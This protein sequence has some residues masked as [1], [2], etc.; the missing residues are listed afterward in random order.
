MSCP[1][2]ICSVSK[3]KSNCQTSAKLAR[4]VNM[5]DLAGNRVSSG[6]LSRL[7]FLNTGRQDF[8][9]LAV[10]QLLLERNSAGFE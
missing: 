9:S 3:L 1:V 2:Q 10:S 6:P 8:L 4:A 5:S 7:P